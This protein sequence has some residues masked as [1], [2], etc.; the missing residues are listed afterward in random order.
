[1]GKWVAELSQHYIEFEKRTSI[2]SEVLADFVADWTPSQNPSEEKKQPE[3]IIY[4]DRAWGFVGA[5]AIAII[6]SPLG[7]KM[8]YAARLEL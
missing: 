4:C 8:R 2:K 6:T 3:W 7:I 1:L 5:G